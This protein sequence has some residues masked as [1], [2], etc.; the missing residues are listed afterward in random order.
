MSRISH[1]FTRE[2]RITPEDGASLVISHIIRGW[3]H[4]RTEPAPPQSQAPGDDQGNRWFWTKGTE[5]GSWFWIECYNVT[6]LS[7]FI[8]TCFL[9]VPH[10]LFSDR[11]AFRYFSL[12]L[13]FRFLQHHVS[14]D[15]EDNV[16][17]Y[18]SLWES[19]TLNTS[20]NYKFI[21]LA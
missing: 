9:T 12:R 4:I 2:G 20:H 13:L 18:Q 10:Q 11:A 17:K 21:T 19:I 16:T 6:L 3:P 15:Q 5:T 7:W 1:I 8:S 14:I